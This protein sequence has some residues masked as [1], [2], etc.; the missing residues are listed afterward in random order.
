MLTM[1]QIARTSQSQKTHVCCHSQNCNSL[2]NRLPGPNVLGLLWH[3]AAELGG[4]LPGV[5]SDLKQVVDQ[6][7]YWGQWEGCHKQCHKAKLDYCRGAN[8]KYTQAQTHTHAHKISIN[9]ITY[10]RKYGIY[11]PH[12]F[13]F[14]LFFFTDMLYTQTCKR[15]QKVPSILPISKY[16]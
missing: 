5:N 2:K 8:L 1:K 10:C 4:N 11:L 12:V 3:Y 7:Q 13:F 15:T 6:C 14:V 9:C 16:S